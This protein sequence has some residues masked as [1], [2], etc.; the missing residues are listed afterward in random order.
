MLISDLAKILSVR[1]REIPNIM[2]ERLVLES[3]REFFR[4]SQVWRFDF[5]GPV[6]SAN[7]SYTP[8]LPT[9]SM[10]HTIL[11]AK[12]TTAN[13]NLNYI[14]D[15][16]RAYA[17]AKELSNS[18]SGPHYIYADADVFTLVPAPNADDTINMRC[19]LTLTRTATTIDDRMVEEYE[20]IICD[21]ALA[22]AYEIPAES[23]S[24]LRR[25][26]YHRKKFELGIEK[27]R[28]RGREEDVPGV[29]VA[30]FSWG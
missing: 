20:D 18:T 1:A 17:T 13:R 22:R 3:A 21:G 25:S 16:A 15:A 11:F 30:Q 10:L 24:S 26:A 12:L 14:R 7:A 9:D 6:T 27:A 8:T 2:L 5:A 4:E 29:R 28:V 23:W 19:A